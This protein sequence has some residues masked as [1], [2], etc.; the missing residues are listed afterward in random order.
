M[1]TGERIGERKCA[2]SGK[3]LLE[4][5]SFQMQNFLV[6]KGAPITIAG[7]AI[8]ALLADICC[9]GGQSGTEGPLPNPCPIGTASEIALDAS[10]E[11]GTAIILFSSLVGDVRSP[12][13]WFSHDE[14]GS[15]S[16]TTLTM[17]L[18][19]EPGTAQYIDYGDNCSYASEIDV[20]ARVSFVTADGAF[21]EQ[22]EGVIYE[23]AGGTKGFRG[24][25][26][27]TSFKGSFDFS[28]ILSNYTNP[29]IELHAQFQPLRGSL[30]V[31]EGSPSANTNSVTSAQI[32]EWGP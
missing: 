15:Y 25:L 10:T 27:L 20:Q 21:S 22:F 26:P 24:Q 16:D 8:V 6:H 4:P 9:S 29:V 5:C 2:V 1:H 28:H 31:S 18:V 13:R 17:S 12:L 23:Q 14:N 19:G 32:A 30:Y 7:F 11:A 3:F